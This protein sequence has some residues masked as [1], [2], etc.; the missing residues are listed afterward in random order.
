MLKHEFFDE[1]Q[2]HIA[3]YSL[4]SHPFYQAWS[5]GELTREDLREYALEYY[6]HVA[7]FPS[8]LAAFADRLPNG[9][10]RDAVLANMNDELGGGAQAQCKPHAELWLDFCEGMGG[11]RE[12]SQQLPNRKIAD[13]IAHFRSAATAGTEEQALAA[14]YVYESQVPRVAAQK[15]CGLRA[16]YGADDRTCSYF[17]LHAVAD[18]YHANVWK[19]QLSKLVRDAS[20]QTHALEAAEATGQALWCGLDTFEEKRQARKAA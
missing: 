19:E 17:T 11:S 18:V 2:K 15:E 4:L 16:W 6:H 12:A 9:H 3:K 13:L 7:A 8:Y 5:A 14:F 10:L 1:L 20:R